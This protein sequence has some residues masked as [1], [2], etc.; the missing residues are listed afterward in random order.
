M[1]GWLTDTMSLTRKLM[2]RSE[3]FR[4]RRLRQERGLCLTDEAEMVEL[5][6]RSHVQEREVLLQCDGRPVVFAHTIV[7]LS[8]TTSDWPFFGTLG[9]RSLGTTLFGD[10]K[11][12]RGRLQYAR[13][14]AQHPLVE[15]ARAALGNDEFAAPLF[16]RRC[17]YRRRNGVLLVTELFLP[18][19]AELKAPRTQPN[20][21]DRLG[22]R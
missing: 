3:H 21:A 22:N 9:E 5:R 12:L 14:R 17:L 8:A 10:P 18:A 1:R 13:L 6:R 20:S 7:P 2:A 11:V 19:I 4:V 16:A 15:R